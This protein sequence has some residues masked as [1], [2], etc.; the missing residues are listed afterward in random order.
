MDELII[1]CAADS[2]NSYPANPYFPGEQGDLRLAEQYIGAVKAGAAMCHIHGV[3]KF[4]PGSSQPKIYHDEWIAL[5]DANRDGV[6]DVVIQNGIAGMAAADKRILYE[7]Q[8][9]EM[10]ST[11]FGPHDTRFRRDP[12]TKVPVDL[13]GITTRADLVEQAGDANAAGVKLEVECFTTGPL[14]LMQYLMERDLLPGP[15]WATMFLG[16]EG[17]CWSPPTVDALSY[18]VSHLPP[19]TN[20]NLSV[21]DPSTAWKLVAATIAMGGHVRVGWEDNPY[22]PNGE[23]ASD[24]SQ[25]VE[26]VVDLAG[27][28]GRDIATPERAREIIGLHAPV[29]A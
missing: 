7:R 1:T 12:G 11:I 5:T 15:R 28:I 9:P 6:D 26:A 16:W 3:A 10:M 8:R 20:W 27:K 2:A 24:N 19:D 21:M 18:M 23:I 29:V 22:L 25:L 17:A 13:Y 14:W 4:E